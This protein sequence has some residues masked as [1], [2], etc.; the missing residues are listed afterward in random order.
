MG[1]T[2]VCGFGLL[3]LHLLAMLI[4]VGIIDI[5]YYLSAFLG[6]RVLAAKIGQRTITALF[7][8]IDAT[9]RFSSTRGLF[10]CVAVF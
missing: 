2:S 5:A 8:N 3:G 10:F 4:A 9:D 7:A 1:A 6:L